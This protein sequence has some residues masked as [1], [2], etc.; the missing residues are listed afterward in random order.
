MSPAD[1]AAEIEAKLKHKRL[2]VTLSIISTIG[3]SLAFVVYRQVSK[4]ISHPPS[5]S[6]PSV[7][8]SQPSD[9]HQKLETTFSRLTTT[10]SAGKSHWDVVIFF[11]GYL[12]NG[13]ENQSRLEASQVSPLI[14]EVRSVPPQNTPLGLP[15]GVEVRTKTGNIAALSY[16]SILISP[17]G[18]E[19]F[20]RLATAKTDILSQPGVSEFVRNVYWAAME[21]VSKSA[22]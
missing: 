2:V 9:P 20:L 15:E 4:I 22:E 19:I 8:L 5:I 3:L 11:D 18:K 12:F 6:L 21:S 16:Q 10:L 13:Q 14:T 17:P 7:S 1:K